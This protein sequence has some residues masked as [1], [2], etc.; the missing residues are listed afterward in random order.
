M[1]VCRAA[2]Y[3]EK[4]RKGAKPAKPTDTPGNQ[5]KDRDGL[6]RRPAVLAR[7][8]EVIEENNNLLRCTSPTPAYMGVSLPPT[9]GGV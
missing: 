3:V 8:D 7:A 5:P 2:A 1:D 4:I 9:P 6:G